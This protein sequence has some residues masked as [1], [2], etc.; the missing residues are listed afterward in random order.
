[1]SRSTLFDNPRFPKGVFFFLPVSN[2]APLFF[3]FFL[4]L[5]LRVRRC[6]SR[7]IQVLVNE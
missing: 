1:M 7:P 3:F 5:P 2:A 6:G 4:L